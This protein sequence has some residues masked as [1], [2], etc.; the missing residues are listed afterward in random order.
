MVIRVAHIP[1]GNGG[2]LALRALITNPAFQLTRVCVSAPGTVVEL[3]DGAK[4][5]DADLPTAPVVIQVP[6]SLRSGDQRSP[7]P[8]PNGRLPLGQAGRRLEARS[9]RP[10]PPR[11]AIQTRRT[12][13]PNQACTAP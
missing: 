13:E 3:V 1:I 9:T 2:R 4:P 7:D 6:G 11:P 12:D 5:T 10:G 8:Q